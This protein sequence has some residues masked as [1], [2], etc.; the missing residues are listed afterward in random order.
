MCIQSYQS[1]QHRWHLHGSC[2]GPFHTHQCLHVEL[3]YQVIDTH[4]IWQIVNPYNYININVSVGHCKDPQVVLTC[5]VD[6]IAYK[7]TVAFTLKATNHIST[8][9][10]H[11][12]VVYVQF[13]IINVCT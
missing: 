3:D 9:G 5:A 13:T 7:S 2:L 8:G 1:H 11:M 12:A 10:I 4:A 6:S